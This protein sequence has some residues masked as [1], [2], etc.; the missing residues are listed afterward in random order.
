MG[1]PILRSIQV[2]LPRDMGRDNVEEPRE[3]SWTSGIV[4][5]PVAGPIPVRR[6]GV[7]GDGQADRVNHGGPDKAICAYSADHYDSTLAIG[8]LS[9]S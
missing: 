3:P 8:Q 4:K 6:T 5:K 2:G 1:T 7:Q 9:S